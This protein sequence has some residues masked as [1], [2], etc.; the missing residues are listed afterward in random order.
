MPNPI[1][2]PPPY[3]SA[4]ISGIVSIVA[5]TFAG[6]KTLL[7]DL[8]VNG[9]TTLGNASGDT[10]TINGT[11]ISI[12]N[13]LNFDTNTLFIDAANNRV[14]IGTTT[15]LTAL[16]VVGTVTT[17]F[18]SGETG[19]QTGLG[20]LDTNNGQVLI[21][22]ATNDYLKL[23]GEG[24]VD[25]ATLFIESGDQGDEPIV[26][27]QK[28]V[29]VRTERL[30][31]ATDGLTLSR[32]DT[33]AIGPIFYSRKARGSQAS[34]ADVANND[35]MGHFVGQGYSGGTYFDTSQI[36]L[37]VDGNITSGQR[38]RSRI[39]L[40]TNNTNQDPAEKWRL[41]SAGDIIQVSTG[42]SAGSPRLY[43]FSLIATEHALLRFGGDFTGVHRIFDGKLMMQ[44]TA[45]IEIGGSRNGS[46]LTAAA[47][48]GATDPSVLIRSP[49]GGG[50]GVALL[51]DGALTVNGNTILG[52]A[53]GDTLTLNGTAVSIPNNLNFDAN[54]LF[55]DAVNNRVGIG[56]ASPAQALDVTGNARVT[57]KMLHTEGAAGSTGVATLVAGTVTVNT[58]AV[59]TASRIQLTHGGTGTVI[60]FGIL[61]VG[62][63][64]DGTSF[65][66]N[67][68]NAADDDSVNWLIIN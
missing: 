10:L 66:I 36:R 4:T 50:T 56:Q 17:A 11:A 58:T 31:I 41:T 62:T 29:G 23:Y 52:D 35:I 42:S 15:P 37:E 28:N 13:S 1:P 54:T 39:T 19:F 40:Y 3:A 64:T 26:F 38:P 22:A 5:Q 63:I 21:R 47:G 60:S 16:H 59:A 8:I 55:L 9:N 61:Y 32:Y 44:S 24:T 30:R 49:A 57:G 67:S 51:V 34:P 20:P 18:T 68:T 12:P 14:G 53:S 46:V 25:N 33:S 6:P 43:N 65:V 7:D 2:S 27:A 48:A 45:G